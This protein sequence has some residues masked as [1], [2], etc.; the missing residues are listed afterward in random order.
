MS[1]FGCQDWKLVANAYSASIDNICLLLMVCF[2]NGLV[3]LIVLAIETIS[4]IGTKFY[5]RSRLI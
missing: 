2:G 5:L 3:W 1:D 4:D